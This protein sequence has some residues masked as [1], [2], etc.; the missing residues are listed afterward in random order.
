MNCPPPIK[1]PHLVHPRYRAD[2]DGLRAVAILS[3]IGYHAFPSWIKGGFVGVDVFFVI[4]GFLISTI[5]FGSLNKDAFSFREFYTR[6]I[7]RIF[8]ALILIMAASYV[9]GWFVLLPDEYR[10]LGKHIA[11]GAG[12]ASNF[13]FWQEAGYFDNAAETKPML[14]L[15]SL[16]IEEQ[17]YIVWPLLLYLTWKKRFNLL[18]LTVAIIAIS[19]TDNVM[20]VH[21]DAV[22][23]FYSPASRFWELMLGS[24]LAYLTLH[25]ISFAGKAKQRI[26]PLCNTQSVLGVVA[27]G[28]AVLLVGRENAFP[29]WWAL[30]PTIGA[31]LIIGAGQD[32]WLNQHL[33]ASRFLVWIGLISYPLYL[34]H[35][36]LLSFAHIV[37]GHVPSNEIR[38]AAVLISIALAWLTYKF[39]ESPIRNRKQEPKKPLPMALCSVMAIV[40][41]IGF[42]TYKWEGSTFRQYNPSAISGDNYDYKS[43]YRYEQCLLSGDSQ[44]YSSA[45]ADSCS[46]VT[47]ST[48][49]KPLVL[50]WG[51]SHAAS[52][53]RGFYNRKNSFNF[54]LA[55]Y[56]ANSCPPII[57]LSIANRLG[58]KE[59]NDYVIQKIK[60]LRPNTVILGANWQLYDSFIN[61]TGK[62]NR[63]DFSKLVLTLQLLRSLGVPNIV[64]MGPLPLFETRQ[65]DVGAKEFVAN[66]KDRTYQNFYAPSAQVN[67]K[68]RT[69]ARDNGIG[70]VSPIDLLCTIDGCLISTSKSKFTPLAWDDAHLTEAGSTLLFD[71]A[72]RSKMLNLP[73]K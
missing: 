36:P 47:N 17:F 44:S 7:K 31:V 15:W 8:P 72:M 56:T 14:H 73:S 2:I 38:I 30:L 3:V 69:F 61:V 68:F 51:D 27:I 50:I 70:Y 32:A 60:A 9:L 1:Q 39:I 5:I 40:G 52:L 55:Q 43:D 62:R 33:L 25:K 34:W 10:Q 63:L 46:G 21:R 48:P 59:T 41:L 16:G 24:I 45:F 19:F 71:L 49:P 65:P 13:F 57:G 12:F 26:T 67:E 42:G 23:A 29:G 37:E 11:A 22:Q 53:Y 28:I 64:L 58:C 66:K 20:K 18:L 6:R 4:S 54:D 35:W